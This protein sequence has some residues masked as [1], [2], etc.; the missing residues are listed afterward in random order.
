MTGRSRAGI[1]HWQSRHDGSQW[2]VG[3]NAIGGPKIS[4]QNK[5]ISDNWPEWYE[6]LSTT[7]NSYSS[8]CNGELVV[9]ERQTALF[10]Q[11]TLQ[12]RLQARDAFVQQKTEENSRAIGRDDLNGNA[13]KVGFYDM[14]FAADPLVAKR[15]AAD[16][17]PADAVPERHGSRDDRARKQLFTTEV[18]PGR[19]RLRELPPQRQHDGQ[20]RPERHVPGLQHPRAGR[21]RRDHG[22]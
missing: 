4:P 9:A 13:F 1:C 21:D 19:R 3:G 15:D 8:S 20:R 5:D 11:A 17:Q 7:M 6:G 18:E 22:R 10:P 2:N 14:A 16:A 12:D